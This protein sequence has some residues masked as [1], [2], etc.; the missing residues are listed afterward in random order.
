ME[1][2][3][4]E[5]RVKNLVAH[6]M[7]VRAKN[8]SPATRLLHDIG[9]DGADGWELMTEF[10]EEFGVDI[11][12]FRFDLHF[13]PEAGGNPF[14]ALYILLVRPRWAQFIPVTIGDLIEAA[15]SGRWHTPNREPE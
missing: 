11:G 5:D 12:E 1:T 14:T 6:K 2:N 7:A 9:A 10:A 15:R 3:S 8:L 4:L 13:G